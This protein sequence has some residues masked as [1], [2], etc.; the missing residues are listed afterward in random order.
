MSVSPGDR[1]ARNP[2]WLLVLAVVLAVV[3]ALA[4]GP[5]VWQANPPLDFGTVEEQQSVERG[6]ALLPIPLVLL[7]GS[8]LF[9]FRRGWRGSAA[10]IA[11]CGVLSV[12][13]A[14][15]LPHTFAAS[16]STVVAGP[17]AVIAAG[18]AAVRAHVQ[19]RS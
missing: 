17:L 19:T 14:L 6:R 16:P 4:L 15:L 11:A 12:A 3:G 10:L 9:V 5:T 8:A 1:I 7:L 18:Y 13:L 2:D